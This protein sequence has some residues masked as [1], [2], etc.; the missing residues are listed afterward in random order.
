MNIDKLKAVLMLFEQSTAVYMKYKKGNE[1]VSFS[2]QDFRNGIS[3]QAEPGD[4]LD[5]GLDTTCTSDSEAERESAA[6]ANYHVVKSP[7]I[8]VVHFE[9]GIDI[10]LNEVSVHKGEILCSIEAMKLFNNIESPVDG[11]I[12]EILVENGDHV[13]CGQILFKIEVI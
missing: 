4:E 7:Y 11:T 6:T 10:R 13:E 9:D 12:I 8:G 2:K 3:H 1:E 5:N